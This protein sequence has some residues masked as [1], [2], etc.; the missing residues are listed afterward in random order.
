MARQKVSKKD[1]FELTLRDKISSIFQK[2]LSNAHLKFVSITKVVLNDDYSHAKVY[3]DSYNVEA[4]GDISEAMNTVK[5]KVRSLL[6][7]VLEIRHTPSIDFYYDS[8]YEDAL[9]IEKLLKH[10]QE[11]K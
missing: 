7:N 11:D 2:D 8:Q 10:E 3:W 4:R 5:A 6:A 9:K 1:S